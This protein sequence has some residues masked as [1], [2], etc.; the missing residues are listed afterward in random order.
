MRRSGEGT[1]TARRRYAARLPAPERREQLLEVAMEIV[2]ERGYRGLTMEAV[3]ARAGVTKP[4]VY[5]AFA[6]RDDVMRALLDAEEQRA[7]A[8]I[9]EAIG[10]PPPPGTVVDAVAFAAASVSRA[11]RVMA[12]R[13]TAYRLILMQIEGTPAPVRSRVDEGRATVVARVRAILEHA[14]AGPDGEPTV[15]AELLALSL[16]ALGEQAAILLL[17]EPGRFPV[18][19]FEASLNALLAGLQR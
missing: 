5:D 19:R 1:R 6:N 17:R 15:D 14:T 12:A 2:G 9:L 16:V 11:L 13:P 18:E 3:A 7:V 8:E 10:P 4:V